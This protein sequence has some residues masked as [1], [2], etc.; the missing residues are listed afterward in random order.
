MACREVPARIDRRRRRSFRIERETEG[1]TYNETVHFR[2]GD[3]GGEREH[4][5]IHLVHTW[6]QVNL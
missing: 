2:L 5:K 1:T 6:V 4:I 3:G